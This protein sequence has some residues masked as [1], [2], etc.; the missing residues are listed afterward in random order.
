MIISRR[1]RR[2]L[3]TWVIALLAG[4]G[5]AAPA[6][7]AQEGAKA[8]PT[9]LQE[10]I[11]V[12]LARQPGLAAARASLAAAESGQSGVNHLPMFNAVV[13]RDVPIRRQQACLG[14]TIAAAGLAQAEWE[15]RYAIVRNYWSIVYAQEQLRLLREILKSAT[16]A[17]DAADKLMKADKDI[18][19][20]DKQ[21]LQLNRDLVTAKEA[22]ARVGVERAKAAVREAMGVDLDYP[23]NNIHGALPDSFKVFTQGDRQEL[24]NRALA[25][26][27]EMAQ[28]VA[29]NQVTGLEITA[30]SRQLFRMT[31]KT[32]AA[33]SDIHATPI[34]QGVAN[35]E[36]RPGAIGLE[37]PDFLV[38]PRADRVQRACNLNDRAGAV[39]DKT[40]N[41][42]TLEVEATLLKIE[43]AAIKAQTLRTSR[44]AAEDTYFKTLE[45]FND[46]KAKVGDLVQVSTLESTIRAYYNEAAYNYV[47]GLAALE[48][49]TAGGYRFPSDL[50]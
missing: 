33:A 36:Y 13:S 7:R 43:E 18:T 6:L 15:T 46:G 4:W 44:K 31:T 24:V 37:M 17:I 42:I 50:K 21:V 34:P 28:V 8:P 47:L 11:D 30:Q 2:V 9:T 5:V 35:G 32:F 22:E 39:V 45:R 12:G 3:C 49:V 26:R 19:K 29:A 27:G 25:L 20:L 41:L 48:R 1:R 14:V 40:Q 38:G 16:D 23:L 10:L